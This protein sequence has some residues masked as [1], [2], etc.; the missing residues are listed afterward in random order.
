MSW[1]QIS[2]CR[3]ESCEVSEQSVGSNSPKLPTVSLS[4][5][6]QRRNHSECLTYPVSSILQHIQRIQK[7]LCGSL[8]RIAAVSP[9]AAPQTHTGCSYET[10]AIQTVIGIV[11]KKCLDLS[12]RQTQ[13]YQQG[14]I[15]VYRYFG[16]HV[17]TR[18][19]Q[20]KER[21]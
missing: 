11:N 1:N 15:T 18:T 17:S 6:W 20:S 8:H 3:V 7:L 19:S 12:I 16:P 9:A 21:L 5:E 14:V 13:K 10:A 4:S 2:C